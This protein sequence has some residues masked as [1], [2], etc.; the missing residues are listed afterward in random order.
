MTRINIRTPV[1]ENF[2]R[3]KIHL[4]TLSATLR[5][6][7][8]S[9]DHRTTCWRSSS[10]PACSWDG[11]FSRENLQGSNEDCSREA[12]TTPH[13]L[14]M[15]RHVQVGPSLLRCCQMLFRRLAGW[16]LRTTWWLE[17]DDSVLTTRCGLEVQQ[18]C[19][20]MS[21]ACGRC[22]RGCSRRRRSHVPDCFSCMWLVTEFRYTGLS[23]SES[24]RHLRSQTSF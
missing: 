8:R 21:W 9:C 19:L 13:L 1:Q 20:Q 7:A 12:R 5:P 16:F 6:S 2:H 23:E 24:A 11:A 4:G 22:P 18:C 14:S 15:C 10:P 3:Y 17:L